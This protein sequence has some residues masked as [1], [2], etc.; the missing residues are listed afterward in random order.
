[1]DTLRT[2]RRRPGRAL[3]PL[4]ASL[5]V[6]A[7]AACGPPPGPPAGARL[8]LL[9]V[10]DTGAEPDRPERL[11]TL[12]GVGAAMAASDEARPADALV[13]LG[14]NFYPDGLRA[15]ELTLRVREDVVRPFC[16]FVAPDAP[17]YAE[18]AD[19][20]PLAD[21]RRHTP[22]IFAVL[23]NHD[24]VAP[25]SPS[26]ERD[27][28]PRFVANWRL[29]GDP[30]SVIEMGRGV[31]LVAFDSNAA[32]AGEPQAGAQLDALADAL[33]R[34][35][36]PWRVLI[37]HHPVAGEGR[38]DEAEAYARYR[39][40]V[41]AAIE[42]AGVDV[43]LALAGHEHSLQILLLDPPGPVLGVVAGAGA[44]PR[45]IHDRNPRRRVAVAHTPGFARV[46]LVGE[47]D[48]ERLVVSLYARPGWPRRL[49]GATQRVALWAV[50]RAGRAAAVEG[51]P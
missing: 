12:R 10:G 14:D 1:M 22:P 37:S 51:A 18:V 23:G 24:I 38:G 45:G 17:R 21:A 36:G 27:A 13:L 11:A 8:S 28:V 5:L 9:A 41:R 50:D 25:G 46:D 33:Q 47:G 29:V 39:R 26:L 4:L 32:F 44:A 49:L 42:A 2:P 30:A 20:C 15:S 19:A 43:Q 34:A 40:G 6:A 35:Q 16:R 48:A 3:W 31:S 7:A